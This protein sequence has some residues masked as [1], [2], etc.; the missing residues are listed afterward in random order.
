MFD[1]YQHPRSPPPARTTAVARLFTSA[2]TKK[3]GEER[4]KNGRKKKDKWDTREKE[5]KIDL[6]LALV[7]KENLVK[8][9]QHNYC[10]ENCGT[11]KTHRSFP[12]VFF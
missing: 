8:Q 7:R 9:K 1:D 3:N 11:F 4:R 10:R 6:D 5:G 2:P 12:S